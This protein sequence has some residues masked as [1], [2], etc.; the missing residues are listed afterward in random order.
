MAAGAV[1]SSNMGPPIVSRI[2]SNIITE[3]KT[4]STINCNSLL[5]NS[6]ESV[7]Q[8]SWEAVH[9]ELLKHMPTLMAVLSSLI[10]KSVERKPL[11]C[12]IASQLL[13]CRHPEM[14]LVQRAVSVMMY[15]N[16]VQKQVLCCYG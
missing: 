16:N 15:G 13:K 8:F 4:I 6:V 7:K 2:C 14:A 9:E 1:D 10:P 11:E 3:M 5:G 12:L